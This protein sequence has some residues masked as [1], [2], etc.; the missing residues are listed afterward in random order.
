MPR[1]FPGIERTGCCFASWISTQPRQ[2]F[3]FGF[4]VFPR[5]IF[6]HLL[7]T[8]GLARKHRDALTERLVRAGDGEDDEEDGEEEGGEE[9]NGH[10]AEDFRL[11]VGDASRKDGRWDRYGGVG[12]S[13]GRMKGE[14][15]SNKAFCV[16]LLAGN[17]RQ[18]HFPPTQARTPPPTRRLRQNTHCAD[19]RALACN[20]AHTQCHTLHT[21]KSRMVSIG[22][23]KSEISKISWRRRAHRFLNV[24]SRSLSNLLSLVVL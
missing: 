8:E 23:I 6:E 19:T 3:I 4:C 20:T 22:P 10:Q 16:G 1:K 18:P 11:F 7:I 9:E 21:Q 15:G 5:S 24:A 13:S 17:S 12:A 2:E 14:G